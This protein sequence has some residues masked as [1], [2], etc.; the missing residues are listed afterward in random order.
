MTDQERIERAYR[1][2]DI[3]HDPIAHRQE[4]PESAWQAALQ[5]TEREVSHRMAWAILALALLPEGGGTLGRWE[6]KTF[7]LAVD[8]LYNTENRETFARLYDR[9][10]G[11]WTHALTPGAYL[12]GT[13]QELLLLM[14][15]ADELARREVQ[16]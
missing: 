9:T 12:D 16:P 11:T 8:E 3:E 7:R 5:S 1:L 13:A 4:T 14:A 15:A 10:E 2:A 6:V